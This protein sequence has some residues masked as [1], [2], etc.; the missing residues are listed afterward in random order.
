MFPS[1]SAP[2][3]FVFIS[4]GRAEATAPATNTGWRPAGIVNDPEKCREK[5]LC[6]PHVVRQHFT[7]ADMNVVLSRNALPYGR[8]HGVVRSA[9]HEPQAKCFEPSRLKVASRLAR[10]LGSETG[11]AGYEVWIAGEGFNTQWHFHAQFR[12]QRSPVWDYID[13]IYP[14]L[15]GRQILADYPSHPVYFG[16]DHESDL[17]DMISREASPFVESKNRP[18]MGLLVSYENGQW[19]SLFVKSRPSTLLF[20]KPPGL[21]EHLGEVVLES[22]QVF[23]EVERDVTAATQTLEN[24][25]SA[26]CAETLVM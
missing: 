3:K 17:L 21:H 25:L 10:I 8:N 22:K 16:N 19:R 13:K 4:T 1:S 23:E 18:A 9:D 11:S 20:G 24:E 26:W 2:V 14:H 6:F 7:L 12:R 15:T 5:F